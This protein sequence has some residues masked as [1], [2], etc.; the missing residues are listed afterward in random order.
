M[1]F[2]EFETML[3]QKAAEIK[4]GQAKLTQKLQAVALRFIDDNFRNQSWEGVPWEKISRTDGTILVHKAKL[5]NSFNGEQIVDGVRIY[6]NVPYAA[7]HNEGFDGQVSIPE[8]KRSRYAKTGK[9]KK[10]KLG[11][12]TVKAHTRVMKIKQR[13]FAPTDSSPSPTLEKIAN[14]TI[15][16]HFAEILNLKSKI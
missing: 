13:Q 3:K 1:T 7:V 12:G 2:D 10:K 6:S 14:Q 11:T 16:E 15:T 5:K 4:N 9:G 8:H